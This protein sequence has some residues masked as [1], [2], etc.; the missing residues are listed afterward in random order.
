MTIRRR[1]F[2]MTNLLGALA[3]GTLALTTT[4]C[5]E[6]GEGEQAG[7]EEEDDVTTTTSALGIG[8]LW[9]GE[10]L[11]ANQE[12]WSPN[13]SFKVRM[14]ATDGNLVIS[15]ESG[16]SIWAS[17]TTGH[18]WG[19][20]ILQSSDGNFVLQHKNGGVPYWSTGPSSAQGAHLAM[21]N[22]GNLVLY[23]GS[24]AASWASHTARSPHSGCVVAGQPNFKTSRATW[25]DVNTDFP[26]H[27]MAPSPILGVSMGACGSECST[28]A[29]TH[30]TWEPGTTGGGLAKCWIKNGTP[31]APVIRSGFRSGTIR[32]KC[33]GCI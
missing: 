16:A 24:G 21:Q 6:L 30:W 2:S 27:D 28:R 5:G 19:Y 32:T 26:G 22:D 14:Q 33:S 12:L 23:K 8:D 4:A 15:R 29:C 1:L 9:E 20:A 7:L 18:P 11:F 25:V 10:Y 3:A 31:S 13:C 17:N